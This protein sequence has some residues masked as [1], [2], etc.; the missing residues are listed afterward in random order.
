MRGLKRS[1]TTT[2][3]GLGQ[4]RAKRII[5][6]R[7]YRSWDDLKRVEGIGDK[8]TEDLKNAGAT[9]GDGR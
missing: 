8:L 7:P 6:N 3:G 9:I 2:V 1:I 4:E 5:E